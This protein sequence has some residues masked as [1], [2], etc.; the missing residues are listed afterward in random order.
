MNVVAAQEQE[1]WAT[2]GLLRGV[3][4]R[5]GSG[6]A[7]CK[8]YW[9]DLLMGVTKKASPLN[10]YSLQTKSLVQQVNKNVLDPHSIPWVCPSSIPKC[11][12]IP[13]H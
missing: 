2:L 7:F 5:Q 12:P 10:P 1:M 6:E 11:A 4:S 13:F 8:S 3:F 9:I